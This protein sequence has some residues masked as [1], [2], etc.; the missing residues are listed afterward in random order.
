MQRCLPRA[1]GPIHA[2]KTCLYDMPPDRD[3]VIDALPEHP[4]ILIGLGAAHGFKFS[5]A[6]GRL[7]SELAVDGATPASLAPFSYNR[8]ILHMVNPPKSFMV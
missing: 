2:I 6:I 4:N 1:V 5:S 8:P 3:F 7:L